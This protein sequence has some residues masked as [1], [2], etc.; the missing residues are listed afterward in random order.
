[1]SVTLRQLWLRTHRWLALSVGWL[2]ACVALMGATLVITG[3]L[4]R[5]FHPEL[6]QARSNGPA[7]A[8]AAPLEPVRQRLLGEF[9]SGAALGFRLPRAAADTLAVTV[10]SG[11]TGTVYIDPASGLEQ[12]RR[13]E[14]EGFHNLL[15]KL[16]S[17][18]GLDELGKAILAWIALAYLFMLV[19]GAILWWPRRWPPVLAVQLRKGLLRGLFDLHRTGGAIMGLLIAVSVASGAYMAWRP[20]GEVVSSIA[21]QQPVK[22]P[23]LPKLAAA[24]ASKGAQL[25]DLDVLLA[26]ARAA[27]PDAPVFVVALPAKPDRAVRVR[28]KRSDDP[29]PNGLSSVWLDPR[30]ARVL[31]VKRWQALDV[32]ARAVA[33]VYPLHTGELGGWSLET[34]VTLNGLALALLGVSGIWLWWKRRRQLGHSRSARA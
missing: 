9:G 21:G 7:A 1:M 33:I 6:F 27:M 28:F 24:D 23:K 22:P 16:H 30:D 17:S 18:L 32:G 5:A 13:G 12:G 25:A 29:H 11:W 31:A 2:L 20:L 4:D 3:P 14:S 34:L 8:L 15:F 19:T 26:N 10:R